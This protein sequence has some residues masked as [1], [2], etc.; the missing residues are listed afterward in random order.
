MTEK[1]LNQIQGMLLDILLKHHSLE[2]AVK[3]I[4]EAQIEEVNDVVTV[5]YKDGTVKI[6][7]IKYA[8]YLD[9]I[10]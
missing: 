10:S 6:L 3:H 8:P 1:R 5:T 7:K 2:K 4:Q 9:E